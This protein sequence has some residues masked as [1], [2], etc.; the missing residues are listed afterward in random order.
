[1]SRRILNKNLK[2]RKKEKNP[3]IPKFQVGDLVED[4]LNPKKICLIIEI[5]ILKHTY[6]KRN[7]AYDVLYS[8]LTQNGIKKILESKAVRDFVFLGK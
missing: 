2:K 7:F 8:V 5:T 6:N 3:P 1:M 4:L